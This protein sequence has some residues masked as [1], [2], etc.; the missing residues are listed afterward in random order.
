MAS[1]ISFFDI[2][3]CGGGSFPTLFVLSLLF[4][5]VYCTLFIL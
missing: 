3:G 2:E 4:I 5:A 1:G